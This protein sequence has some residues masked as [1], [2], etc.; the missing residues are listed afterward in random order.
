MVIFATAIVIGLPAHRVDCLSKINPEIYS[1]FPV[2]FS[3]KNKLNSLTKKYFGKKA[4]FTKELPPDYV[5][6][7]QKALSFFT[8]ILKPDGSFPQIGDN[9]NGRFFKLNPHYK[10]LTTYE[11]KQRYLNLKGYDDL[12]DDELYYYEEVCNGM[13]VI[14]NAVGIGLK[15]DHSLPIEKL[16]E[17]IIRFLCDGGTLKLSEDLILSSVKDNKTNE[18]ILSDALNIK[19]YQ[20]IKKIN[21][22]LKREERADPLKLY[23][24]P[25]FG[26]HVWKNQYI[27]ISLRAIEGNIYSKGHFHDDQMSLEITIKGKTVIRD[28]GTF[29]YTAF[30]HERR[31]YRDRGAHFPYY[32]SNLEDNLKVFEAPKINPVEILSLGKNG[33]AGSYISNGYTHRLVILILRESIEI[34]T[35]SE[36]QGVRLDMQIIKQIDSP[37]IYSPG[38]GIQELII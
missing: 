5:E 28:P 25:N 37:I 9:D 6:R 12:N 3:I 8:A 20:K 30:P 23:S 4:I 19:A 26:L 33:F 31:S 14:K 21:L 35:A 24:F 7:I 18:C 15:V 1:Y 38:Y 17:E 13:D 2:D 32:Q 27:Y 22:N 10:I 16:N 36:T 34:L 29:T 11:A